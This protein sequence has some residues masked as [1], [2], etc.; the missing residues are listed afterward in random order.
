MP[1]LPKQVFRAELGTIEGPDLTNDL[2]MDNG[3][4]TRP[5]G[6]RLVLSLEPL[7]IRVD[8]G[9]DAADGEN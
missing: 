6:M 4:Y 7:F 2:G 9:I 3:F 5:Q 8:V 1:P